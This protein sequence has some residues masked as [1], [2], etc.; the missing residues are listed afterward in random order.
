MREEAAARQDGEARLWTKD[1]VLISLATFFIFMSF[2]M[3]MPTLPKYVQFLGAKESIVGLV[4]GVF[5]VSAVLI[6]PFVG[7]E[8]DRR[9]R[10]GLY[11]QGL[12][13]FI[14]SVLAYRWAPT[15]VV[16]LAI[17]FI[18]GLGWGAV[19]TAAGTIVTDLLPPAR[20]GEGMGYYGMFSN[21]AMAVAP[22]TGL[23]LLGRYNY[24]PVFFV[25][26]AFAALA[27][28]LATR[29][30]R[31]EPLKGENL[32]APALFE[33]RTLQP[34]LVTFLI[35]LSYGC[36]VTFL[37]LYAEH[38]GISNIG[39]FFT[40]YAVTLLVIRPLAGRLYDR[41]GPPT[42]L[43][44]GLALLI[45]ALVLLSRAQTWAAFLLAGTF[46]G[47]GFGSAQPALQA[48][49]VADVPPSR[50][51][52]ANATFFS[53]FDLGIGLG[54]IALGMVAQ[55]IGYP[56]MFLAAAGGVILALAAYLFFHVLSRG[57]KILPS[58]PAAIDQELVGK[59]KPK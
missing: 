16:V 53:A 8:L 4:T 33:P 7:R 11:L 35:A 32:P 20:R 1:F 6:R 29:L 46:Y 38:Q 27:F 12:G 22:A 18:H 47:L 24:P 37:P 34:A 54:A 48:L 51:G 9:G 58:P 45:F 2:Q 13:L 14:F 59:A 44:P 36:L 26:A 28:L 21:L 10:R 50:R 40:V 5:T 56:G 57:R 25:A 15:A 23:F 52:A 55:S 43:V 39:P 49:T 41:Y 19:T 42:A 3:T 31:D 30:K 17:R